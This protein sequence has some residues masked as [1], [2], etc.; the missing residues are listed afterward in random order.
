MFLNYWGHVP[1]LPLKVYAYGGRHINKSVD[2]TDTNLNYIIVIF[3]SSEV[4]HTF[5]EGSEICDSL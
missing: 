2:A 3:F 1:G 4:S 5:G